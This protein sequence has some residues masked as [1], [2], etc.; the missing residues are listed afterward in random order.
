MRDIPDLELLLSSSIP[1]VVIETHEE[2]RVIELF[3]QALVRS[4]KPFYHWTVTDGL[5]RLDR[6][7]N[8]SSDIREPTDVLLQIKTAKEPA[9]YLLSDFHPYLEDPVHVR[10]LRDVAQNRLLLG[11]TV[12]LLSHKLDIPPE[13]ARSAARFS[14]SVPDRKQLK[15][16]VLEE[17]R[18]WSRRNRGRNV[19]TRKQLLDRL[20]DNL[21]GLPERDAKRLAR[22]AIEDD[23]AITEEDLPAVMQAKF[24]LLGQDGVLS[25]EYDTARFAEVGGL[26][27]LKHWLGLRE[28]VFA[29]TLNK[30]GLDIPKGILLLGVQGCGKSLAAKAVA[31]SWAV[32]LLRL[33]FGTLYN[34]Y[35]GETERNLREALKQAE[36]MAPCVLWIDE[37]EKGL[38]TDGSDSGTSR[39]VLGTLLTWMAENTRRIFLVATAN[40]IDSL[41]AELLRKGRMDEIFFVDLP[42]VD[43]RRRIFEIHLARRELNAEALDLEAL[44]AACDG[45]SGAEIEQVVVAGLYSSHA[46]GQSLDTAALLQ[47][48]RATRPL[49]VVMAERVGALRAW[50]V[51]RTVPA[52]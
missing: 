43:T 22:G 50:A 12:V 8:A 28:P 13:L 15:T 24:Q 6:G 23:G 45:F 51:E 9:I 16:I 29:G 21:S 40:D 2:Q 14:L 31:G 20:V 18:T 32:P 7:F 27:R 1:I 3:R 17:A 39:R 37:I 4:P 33:D 49:S 36:T 48:I 26:E 52:N 34:K 47:E 46:R 35:Y 44:A 41:P 42:D 38:S 5:R 30:P 25:Y 19:S 10:L 11:H